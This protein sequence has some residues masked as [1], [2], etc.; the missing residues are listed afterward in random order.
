MNPLSLQDRLPTRSGG[1]I[2]FGCGA[3]NSHGLKIKRRMEG[4]ECVCRFTPEDHH[5][6]FPNILNGG[7]IATV[8]D[9]HAIWTAVGTYLADSGRADEEHPATM[10]VTKKMTVEF[11]S[12][13]PMGT[14]LELR[15]RVEESGTRSARVVVELRAGD[16]LTARAEVLAVRVED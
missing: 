15:G 4:R 2:C 11:L 14:A 3:D 13:T 8:L 16:A 9:C 10:Y 7:I 1:R 12:S 6:A 5:A